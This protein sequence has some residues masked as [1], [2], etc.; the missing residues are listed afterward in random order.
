MNLLSLIRTRWSR[1]GQLARKHL[2]GSGIEIGA[3]HS[4]TP[5]GRGV[6]VQYVD[7]LNGQALADHYPEL[8]HSQFVPV[9]IV[10]DAQTLGTIADRSQDFVVA[11]HVLEHCED[12]L[13]AL[14]SWLRVLR[15]GGRVL[16]AVPNRDQTFDRAREVTDWDHLVRDHEQDPAGSRAGH[17]LEWSTLV[18]GKSGET[19]RQQARALEASGYSIH[20]HVWDWERFQD[21][22]HRAQ[23]Y[24][25]R[26]FAIDA[27]SDRGGEFLAVLRKS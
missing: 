27:L 15:P 14:A 13:G 21:F 19:A 16:L 9:D 26:S 8:D 12:P 23:P 17:Y 6:T 3:L 1:R 25:D 4:P 11:S 5:L 24:L 2:R 18:E 22:L 7:R 20:F 10:D